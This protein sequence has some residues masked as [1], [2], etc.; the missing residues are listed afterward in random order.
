[1]TGRTVVVYGDDGVRILFAQGTHDVVG[2]FLHFRIGALHGVQLDAGGV[3][4]C[5][6][7]RH[8]PATEADA[9]VVTAHDHDFVTCFGSAFQAVALCAVA[10]AA[11][12]HDDLVIAIEHIFFFVFKCQDRAADKRLAEFV[13]EVGSAV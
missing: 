10:H 7:G 2:A 1:M 9:V 12:E 5:V 4:A 8:R 6:H 3:A 11:G 13:S